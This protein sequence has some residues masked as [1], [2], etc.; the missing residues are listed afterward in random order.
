M[1]VRNRPRVALLVACALTA[2]TST[3]DPSSTPSYAES[4]RLA[5]EH[6]STQDLVAGLEALE[7]WHAEN[8]TAVAPRFA[9]GIREADLDGLRGRVGA[10]LPDELVALYR[11][12]DGTSGG[13][14]D[15]AGPVFVAYHCM[16]S[17][18]QALDIRERDG[19]LLALPRTWL[20]VLYF[21][22]EYFYVVLDDP[23][24][25]ALPVFHRLME[26][27]NVV[28]FTNVQTMV[29]TF[30]EAARSG[31]W[32]PDDDALV[33]WSAVEAI[34]ARLNPGTSPPWAP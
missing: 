6:A 27:E 3:E 25:A 26:S 11:W 18:Q 8:Q 5:I 2:C 15:F 12:H 9:P 28:A 17:L 30:V 19:R 1:K 7:A 16:L 32:H 24:P 34:R 29:A 21:Q 4:R 20:P 14:D 10:P 33:D 22:E 31:V 13:C 23:A